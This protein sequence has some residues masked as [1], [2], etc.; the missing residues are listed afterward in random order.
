MRIYQ[1]QPGL[2]YGGRLSVAA[3]Y[4]R[5]SMIGTALINEAVSRAR[6]IGCERFLATVQQSNEDYFQRLHWRTL[7]HIELHG[8]PHAVMQVELQHYPFMPREIS[9]LPLRARRHG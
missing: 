6:D 8:Q 9:L 4:R 1:S 3:D 2:W 5:H 7:E